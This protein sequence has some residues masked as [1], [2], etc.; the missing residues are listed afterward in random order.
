M[1]VLDGQKTA[2]PVPVPAAP[3]PVSLG[4]AR[5]S[6]ELK[7]FF[8]QR[9]TVVFTFSLPIVM[10]A[11][12]G[13]VF[14]RDIEGTGVTASQVF[15][16][17]IIGGG[18]ASTSFVN[19]GIGIATDRENGTLKRLRGTPIPAL[20]YFLGKIILVLVASLAEVAILL[21]VG[22]A[23]FDLDLPA[24]VGP[25]LT[26]VWVF[27]LGVAA[28]S[29][30]GIAVTSVARTPR[31]A[32]AF[33]NMALL[34]LQFASGIFVVPISRLPEPL[35]Q[36]GSLFPLRWMAQGFRSVFLPDAAAQLEMVG[37]WEHARIALILAAWCVG[38]LVLCLVTF[39]WQDRRE[40]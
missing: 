27:V 24:E 9:D 3:G 11:I 36:V 33:T 30:L 10:L 14:G 28:C 25:W 1:T 5:A 35:V 6:V 20:S 8:R 32:V 19:L 39:R 13:S 7:T 31:S 40:R 2:A 38:G 16:A 17:G 34:V 37:A 15:T 26:F 22:Y 12:L 23:F 29:L 21:S 18:V 4:L